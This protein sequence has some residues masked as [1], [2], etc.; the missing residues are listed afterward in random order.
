[1]V[2]QNKNLIIADARSVPSKV[3]IDAKSVP[4]PHY[5][6]VYHHKIKLLYLELRFLF[7]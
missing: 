2:E 6:L 4:H 7:S 3:L 1:M 5:H